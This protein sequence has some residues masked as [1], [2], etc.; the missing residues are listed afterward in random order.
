MRERPNGRQ[1]VRRK[2]K[3]GFEQE[4][5]NEANDRFRRCSLFVNELLAPGDEW[6]VPEVL[7]AA[8]EVSAMT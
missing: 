5:Q 4:K 1:T 2:R 3:R 7:G 6:Q 8:K